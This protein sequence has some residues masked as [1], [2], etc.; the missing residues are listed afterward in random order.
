MKSHRK[1]VVLLLTETVSL[2][3]IPVS[4]VYAAGAEC[5]AGGCAAPGGDGPL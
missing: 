4:P 5:A 1:T 3:V 2:G